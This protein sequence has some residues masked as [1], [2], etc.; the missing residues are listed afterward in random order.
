VLHVNL[1]IYYPAHVEDV[2]EAHLDKQLIFQLALGRQFEIELF[3]SLDD[4]SLILDAWDYIA[5]MSRTSPRTG[6]LSDMATINDWAAGCSADHLD[7][8]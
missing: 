7:T 8:L 2:D 4:E 5:T 1:R 6:S 3:A